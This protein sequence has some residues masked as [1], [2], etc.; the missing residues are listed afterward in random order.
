MHNHHPFP[1]FETI[2]RISPVRMDSSF[3]RSLLKSY[4]TLAVGFFEA[5]G[6]EGGG[7]GGAFIELEES[8][9]P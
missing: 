2:C 3:E 6:A 5:G 9:R 1:S 8:V 7:G 4:N